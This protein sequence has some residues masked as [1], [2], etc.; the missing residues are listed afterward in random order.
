MGRS[1]LSHSGAALILFVCSFLPAA[2]ESG[3]SVCVKMGLEVLR[4]ELFASGT[5]TRE[6]VL[7]GPEDHLTDLFLPLHRENRVGSVVVVV[8]S[9][10][11]LN[12]ENLSVWKKYVAPL[13]SASDNVFLLSEGALEGKIHGLGVRVVSI[14]DWKGSAGEGPAILDLSFLLAIYKDELRTPFADLPRKFLATIEDR[15]L[16]LSRLILWTADR[17][18]IPLGRGYLPKLVEEAVRNPKMFRED[19]PPKWGELRQ[20]EYLAFLSAFDEAT[21][22]FE[23]YLK[24]NPEDPSV[25]YQIAQMHF[26]DREIE[27]GMRFLQRAYKA[28]FFYIRAY[29]ET[30]L[31][32]FRAGKLDNAERV[33]RAGLLQEPGNPELRKGLAYVLLGQA[34]K[35]LPADPETAGNRFSEIDALGLPEEILR[36]IRAEWDQAKTAPPPTEQ[37]PQGLPDAH[38][39]F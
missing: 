6:I 3:K 18:A 30:A 38:P 8:P 35:F 2:A 14:R 21:V 17:D 4:E 39:N 28:D 34:R 23:K 15:N 1:F 22:H 10:T 36:P 25:L 37:P 33:L 32:F 12:G 31:R 13:S 9:E 29:S 26:V 19:L 7:F 27:R 5:A 16:H 20:A 24:E 11:S